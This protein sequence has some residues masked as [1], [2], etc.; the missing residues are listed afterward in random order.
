MALTGDTGTVTIDGD[1]VT[2]VIAWNADQ[3]ITLHD[4]SV[5]SDTGWR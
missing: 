4:S 5:M 3:D 2:E 1:T